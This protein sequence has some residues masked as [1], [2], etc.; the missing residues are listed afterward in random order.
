MS[1]QTLFDKHHLKN[2]DSYKLHRKY[3]TILPSREYSREKN[4]LNM[5]EYVTSPNTTFLSVNNPRKKRISGDS[6]TNFLSAMS[7]F[8]NSL[9]NC[10]KDR[11]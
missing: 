11:L 1:L 4:T 5:E 2:E 6:S 8:N 10:I 9:L 3:T 7:I